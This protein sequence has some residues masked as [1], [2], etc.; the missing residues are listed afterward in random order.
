MEN[1]GFSYT[2]EDE[3]ILE[4][5]KLTVEEKL[6]WLEEIIELTES[7]LTEKEKEFRRRLMDGTI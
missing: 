2:L 4:Y 1:K 3:K 5:M 6:Q 7:T